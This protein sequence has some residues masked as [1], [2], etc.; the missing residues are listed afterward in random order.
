[1]KRKYTTE[2]KHWLEKNIGTA[3]SSVIAEKFYTVFGTTI[4]ASWIRAYA[5]KCGLSQNKYRAPYSL[6]SEKTM[7]DGYV[8]IKINMKGTSKKRCWKVKHRWVWE[9]ANGKIPKGRIIIFLDGNHKNIVLE[10]LEMITKA[11][12][13]KLVQY[14]LTSNNREIT[15][16][17]IAV[18]R[19]QLKI[20]ELLKKEMGKKEHHR[21]VNRESNKRRR[22]RK[23]NANN[24]IPNKKVQGKKVRC[25]DTGVVYSSA[26]EASRLLGF[27]RQAVTVA[28]RGNW[29][30]GGYN[31]EYL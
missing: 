10:N 8:Y 22:L 4:A 25:I 13:V 31:W 29:R 11:E 2:H 15:L 23:K 18:V 27:S 9:Q 17:G 28:I 7:S 3:P 16:A 19:H 21:F 6:Y 20:H 14:G 30:S 1:M 26:A 12:K 24:T 5:S